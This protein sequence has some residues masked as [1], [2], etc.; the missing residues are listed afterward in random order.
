MHTKGKLPPIYICLSVYLLSIP[1]PLYFN[2]SFSPLPFHLFINL[3][4]FS[5]LPLPPHPPPP[6]FHLLL[7][8]PPTLNSVCCVISAWAVTWL[9]LSSEPY[10]GTLTVS[11]LE[12][13]ING[14][15]GARA[16]SNQ[17][18]WWWSKSKPFAIMTLQ[19]CYPEWVA[20]FDFG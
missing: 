17:W 5:L 13:P 6:S 7:L 2:H 19:N 1:M 9:I 12:L 15:T 10:I 11:G 20:W 18:H 3:Y 16:V 4:S 14:G 8:T